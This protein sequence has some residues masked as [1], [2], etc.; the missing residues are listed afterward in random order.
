VN[1]LGGL[2]VSQTKDTGASV[3]EEEAALVARIARGDVNEPVAELHRRYGRRLYRFAFQY[4]RNDGLAQEM[5]Q[6]TFV[7]LWRGA[8]RFDASKASVGT[9]LFV[10]ARS[11]ALDLCKRPSSRP[12]ASDAD[13]P[14]LAIPDS[15]D[16]IINSLVI[17]EALDSLPAAQAEV[18]RLAHQEGLTQAQIAERLNEPLG[19]VKSRMFNGMRALRAALTERGAADA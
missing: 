18:I 15:V 12:F 9:Y 1:L 3:A 8:G 6:E 14:E 7:R 2:A 11:T 16:Q 17:R 5:V 10:L 4:L 19:T 13:I